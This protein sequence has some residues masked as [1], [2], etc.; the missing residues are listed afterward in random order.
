MPFLVTSVQSVLAVW[1]HSNWHVEWIQSS[2][3]AG[4]EG[5]VSR[6]VSTRL[7]AYQKY[8]LRRRNLDLLRPP[9]P[10]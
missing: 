5:G 7:N 10:V 9:L 2:E 6:F 3:A 4:R 1:R 8:C